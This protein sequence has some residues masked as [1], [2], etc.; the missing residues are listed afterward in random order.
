MGTLTI[1]AAGFSNL[2]SSAPAN[3]PSDV[4]FPASGNP[5][6][7]KTYTV[8]DADWLALLTWVADSQFKGT[9]SGPGQVTP[10]TPT[11]A[12]ILLAWLAIW[13]NGSK[14]AVQQYNTAPPQ[15]PAP[16][17]IS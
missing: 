11:A 1:T 6:G 16:I 2:G 12:Q 9:S 10:A 14:S 7:T 13:I 17:G 3:W 5:N 4:T 15:V 8:N